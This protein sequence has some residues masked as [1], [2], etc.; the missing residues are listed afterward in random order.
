M[1]AKDD[2]A[3]PSADK[4]RNSDI[5]RKVDEMMDEFVE[6]TF[7]ASDPPAWSSLVDWLAKQV[8]T[9]NC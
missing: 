5:R 4:Q 8:K 2:K 1:K 3:R 7:P 9:E 6:E